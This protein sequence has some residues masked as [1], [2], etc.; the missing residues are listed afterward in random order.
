MV[1]KQP[2]RVEK[3]PV[4]TMDVMRLMNVNELSKTADFFYIDMEKGNKESII[5]LRA[6]LKTLFG[7]IKR[8]CKEKYP[9][10]TLKVEE[11]FNKVDTT[12]NFDTL[13]SNT[14]ESFIQ[15][16][17]GLILIKDIIDELIDE[18]WTKFYE[19]L[20]EEERARM[21]SLGRA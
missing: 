9:T 20:P 19:I 1:D 6:T 4:Y 11:A 8:F 17:N 18:I 15:A 21:Y 16:K 7:K 13:T 5:P 3:K 14:E 2:I 12:F 10:E